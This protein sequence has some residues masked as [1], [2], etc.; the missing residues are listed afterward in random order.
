MKYFCF[1]LIFIFLVLFFFLFLLF[2]YS[3]KL[4]RI[5]P[6]IFLALILS[7]TFLK[8][9]SELTYFNDVGIFN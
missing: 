8:L 5:R 4:V 7:F 6:E 9:T 3:D 2:K 1:F